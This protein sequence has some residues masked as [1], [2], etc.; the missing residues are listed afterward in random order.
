MWYN[1]G[2]WT[3]S[4]VSHVMEPGLNSYQCTNLREAIFSADSN[5]G[6][7]RSIAT[8]KASGTNSLPNHCADHH[9][10]WRPQLVKDEGLNMLQI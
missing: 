7:M 10:L 1:L 4:L 9:P 2:F 6:Q 8:G 3:P 5:L